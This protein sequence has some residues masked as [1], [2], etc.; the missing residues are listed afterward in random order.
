MFSAFYG[1]VENQAGEK[2]GVAKAPR[3]ALQR[4]AT[5]TAKGFVAHLLRQTNR[6]CK[7][8]RMPVIGVVIA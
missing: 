8:T 1:K 3:P 2:D 4:T 7:T 6:G 5:P